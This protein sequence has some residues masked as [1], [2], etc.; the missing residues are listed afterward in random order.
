MQFYINN[1]ER[2]AQGLLILKMVVENHFQFHLFERISRSNPKLSGI[3]FFR[4][5]SLLT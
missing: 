4:M 2:E 5:Q 1:Q 3:P